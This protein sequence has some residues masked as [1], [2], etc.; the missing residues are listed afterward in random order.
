M[1]LEILLIIC[2]KKIAKIN[3]E[4]NP[5]LKTIYLRASNEIV[6]SSMVWELYSNGKPVQKYLPY[7]E[8]VLK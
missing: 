8:G 6:S 2:M 4:I 7:T 3:Q 5:D 1:V